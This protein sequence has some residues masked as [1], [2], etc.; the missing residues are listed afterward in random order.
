GRVDQLPFVQYDFGY[1]PTDWAWRFDH[2]PLILRVVT[3][4]FPRL[5]VADPRVSDEAIEVLN[6]RLFARLVKSI[7]EDG[8]APLVVLMSPGNA[9]LTATLA[10]ARLRSFDATECL[11]EVPA[12][13][14]RV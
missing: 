6:S 8:A 13:R 3:S 7:E 5:T 2:G 1:E 14:R 10:R 9:L 11:T 4:A 12:D